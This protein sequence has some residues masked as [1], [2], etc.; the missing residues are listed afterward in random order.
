M[1][2]FK[3]CSN[4][5][6]ILF[7]CLIFIYFIYV[8]CSQAAKP[9]GYKVRFK[10]HWKVLHF[11]LF[12]WKRNLAASGSLQCFRKQNNI[13]AP[14]KTLKLK[15]ILSEYCNTQSNTFRI[16]SVF[17]KNYPSSLQR[18]FKGLRG[19]VSNPLY[20][21][22]THTMFILVSQTNLNIER[23]SLQI[24]IMHKNCNNFPLR[25]YNFIKQCSF[26]IL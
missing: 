24:K 16:K 4:L 5:F 2:H 26:H 7:F 9:A 21:S 19:G 23:N 25:N 15:A 10:K 13:N 22:V 12:K 20:G 17:I 6:F 8:F 3:H 1:F 18:E 14:S 11:L